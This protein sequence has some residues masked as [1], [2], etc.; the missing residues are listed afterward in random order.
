MYVTLQV[1]VV[2]L[3]LHSHIRYSS[4]VGQAMVY[5]PQTMLDGQLPTSSQFE[6]RIQLYLYIIIL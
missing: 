6:I 4:I 1:E 2:L 5:Q 3:F